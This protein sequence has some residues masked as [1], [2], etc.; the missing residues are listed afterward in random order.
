MLH[1]LLQTDSTSVGVTYETS[2]AA[3]CGARIRSWVASEVAIASSLSKINWIEEKCCRGNI[4]H[5]DT[6][7]SPRIGHC[8]AHGGVGTSLPSMQIELDFTYH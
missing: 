5:P 6:T 8:E 4:A 1:G 7:G 2:I 3:A